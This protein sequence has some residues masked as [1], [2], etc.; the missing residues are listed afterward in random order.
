MSW[1]A[2]KAR[3]TPNPIDEQELLMESDIYN[4]KL[5]R[6]AASDRNR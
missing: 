5:V 1:A 6:A 2:F 3:P 4:E